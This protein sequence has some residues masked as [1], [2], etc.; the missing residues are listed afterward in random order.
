MPE[1]FPIGFV[2]SNLTP[3]NRN[4]EGIAHIVVDKKYEDALDGI[5]EFSH[6]YVI[7][8]LHLVYEELGNKIHPKHRQDLPLVGIFATHTQ[9]RPNH[10]GLTVVELLERRGNILFVSGLDAFDGT[11]VLD[12]KPYMNPHIENLRQPQWVSKLWGKV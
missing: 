8:H 10:I 1:F 4:Y 11:P 7:F 3:Q 9:Y 12:I 5:E 6:L 2:K